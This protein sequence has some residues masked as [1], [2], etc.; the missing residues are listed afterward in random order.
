[1]PSILYYTLD[2]IVGFGLPVVVF[3]RRKRSEW[4]HRVNKLFWLG[5][6]V[7]L[8]WEVP[9]FLSAILSSTPVI[10][11]IEEPPLDPYVFLISH[12]LWDGGLFVGG[13]LLLRL[14]FGKDA[15]QRFQWSELS[16]LLIWGQLSA[17]AVEISS[18]TSEGWVY[19]AN[20]PWNTALFEVGGHPI[21][22]LPQAIWLFAPVVYYWLALKLVH[23]LQGRVATLSL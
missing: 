12:T 11:F 1:M 18:V 8:T 14:V 7:G 22:A 10:T 21:T 17:F 4:D 9:I 13:V 20:H 3:A 15:L 16:L 6:A 5:S 19:V 2:L 23:R